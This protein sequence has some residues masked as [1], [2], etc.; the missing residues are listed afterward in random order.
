MD[1]EDTQKA[2]ILSKICTPL[3][4]ISSLSLKFKAMRCEAAGIVNM[5]D[6]FWP[7]CLEFTTHLSVFQFLFHFLPIPSNFS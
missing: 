6:I 4:N 7:V 3:Q 5:I 1:S 2:K